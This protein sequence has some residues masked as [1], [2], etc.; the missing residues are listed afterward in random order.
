MSLRRSMFVF[1]ALTY[2][3]ASLYSHDSSDMRKI[4]HEKG[5]SISQKYKKYVVWDNLVEPFIIR[6]FGVVFG[7]GH[8]FIKGMIS[9]NSIKIDDQLD[10]A[11]N[12][13]ISPEKNEKK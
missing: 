5:R 4:M 3:Y 11:I 10:Q 2:G 1:S 13:I 9:D 6:Q 12:S 8:S 7:I